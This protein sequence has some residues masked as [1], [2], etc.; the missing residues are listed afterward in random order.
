MEAK[1]N[2]VTPL[3]MSSHNGHLA[4]ARLLLEADADKDKAA[5]RSSAEHGELYSI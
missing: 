2:G 4:V 1:N 3:V 5:E